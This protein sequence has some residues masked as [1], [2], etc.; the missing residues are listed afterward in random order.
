MTGI[1]SK[2]LIMPLTLQ[3][4]PSVGYCLIV[5]LIVGRLI[6]GRLPVACLRIVTDDGAGPG[7]F[8]RLDHDPCACR[9]I[10]CFGAQTRGLGHRRAGRPA[11][12]E[13]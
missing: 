8:A 11:H 10:A 1:R 13:P 5:R 2:G 12:N 6:V 3:A 9:A 4:V 7:R